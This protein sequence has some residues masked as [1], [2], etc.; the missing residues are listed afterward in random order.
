MSFVLGGGV[1]GGQY[2]AP[3]SL[4]DLVLGDNLQHT[5][6]FRRVYATLIEE[7]LGYSKS[8]H[9]LGDKFKTFG[10]FT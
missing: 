8:E 7:F 10:M 9:V 5:T 3:P 4:T 1:T 2:S 6:D